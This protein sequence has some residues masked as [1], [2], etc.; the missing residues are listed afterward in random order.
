LIENISEIKELEKNFPK[1]T[2][3][4]SPQNVDL[5]DGLNIRI[6]SDMIISSLLNMEDDLERIMIKSKF[7]RKGWDVILDRIPVIGTKIAT[8][9]KPVHRKDFDETNIDCIDTTETDWRFNK[10]YR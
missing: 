9:Q 8:P 3:T 7:G 5:G 6:T 10:E 2:C 1:N 4:V